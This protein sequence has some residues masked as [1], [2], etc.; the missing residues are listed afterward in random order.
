MIYYEDDFIANSDII[1]QIIE[2]IFKNVILTVSPVNLEIGECDTTYNMANIHDLERLQIFIQKYFQVASN[3]L[4]YK[5]TKIMRDSELTPLCS[6]IV[7]DFSIEEMTSSGDATD[8]SMA[9]YNYY[10]EKLK[11]NRQ[12]YNSDR[13]EVDHNSEQQFLKQLCL[14][15]FFYK[16]YFP[17]GLMPLATDK[18]YF[19]FKQ[20]LCEFHADD[21]VGIA[22]AIMNVA[23]VYCVTKI[24]RDKLIKK[25]RVEADKLDRLKM[26]RELMCLD[27]LKA[28]QYIKERK[29]E[30]RNARIE[31]HHQESSGN[32]FLN[33]IAN[34]YARGFI[35]TKKEAK[36]GNLLLEVESYNRGITKHDS[37]VFYAIFP[38]EYFNYPTRENHYKSLES[39]YRHNDLFTIITLIL[40]NCYKERRSLNDFFEGRIVHWWGGYQFVEMA[41]VILDILN[42]KLGR[43]I[44]MIK[45][46]VSYEFKWSNFHKYHSDSPYIFNPKFT[47]F[48]FDYAEHY[49]RAINIV[50]V[51]QS[52]VMSATG[53]FQLIIALD[54]EIDKQEGVFNAIVNSTVTIIVKAYHNHTQRID[55]RLSSSQASF[56]RS[57]MGSMSDRSLADSDDE[58]ETASE[59]SLTD[60]AEKFAFRIDSETSMSDLEGGRRSS[61]ADRL[62]S[63]RQAR[64]LSSQEQD[65]ANSEQKTFI[66]IDFLTG[67]EERDFKLC[68]DFLL[69]HSGNYIDL[70][71]IRNQLYSTYM[72]REIHMSMHVTWTGTKQRKCTIHW[73]HIERIIQI[74]ALANMICRK[75]KLSNITRIC[76]HNFFLVQNRSSMVILKERQKKM[77]G[78][79][80]RY[81]NHLRAK[82][83]RQALD[84]LQMKWLRYVKLYKLPEM[85]IESI[86][87][88]DSDHFQ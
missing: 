16:Y 33:A 67:N 79:A 47:A 34:V 24:K 18:L 10:I 68:L 15:R 72:A 8:F 53:A 80:K 22:D 29:D 38:P 40:H 86:E 81:F 49:R 41:K 46:N 43:Y 31:L 55:R 71:N 69:Q 35:E 61:A 5:K 65:D 27:K 66:I 75:L 77:C 2:N 6:V 12:R 4:K 88:N 58:Y 73:S 83:Y 62:T 13:R 25:L 7:E 1:L 36:F 37:G 54:Q 82:E 42:S 28:Y 44:L 63:F 11:L 9:N 20:G 78:M 30:V 50:S 51:C 74:L 52:K 32:D 17:Q 57:H 60:Y 3:P 56:S 76:D 14:F 48:R 26:E 84:E 19:S 70:I 64:A 59:S 45:D 85:H 23:G 21:S 39:T 87:I